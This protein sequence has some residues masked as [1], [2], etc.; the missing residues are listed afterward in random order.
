MNDQ[1][2]AAA[3]KIFAAAA[4]LGTTRQEAILVT[5]ALAPGAP[6]RSPG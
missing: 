3:E 2:R 5:R 1:V 4:E 6:P